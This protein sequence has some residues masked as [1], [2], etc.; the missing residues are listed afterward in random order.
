MFKKIL[1]GLTLSVSVLF[2]DGFTLVSDDLS[3]QLTND[4]VFNGFGCSGKNISPAL[5][6]KNAPKGTKSFAITMYDKDAPTG[7]GWWHWV[8]FDIPTNVTSLPKNSGDV[9][10]NLMPKGAIQSVTD[11]G[12]SG[13]GGACP[14]VGHG[15]HQYVITIYALDVDTLGLDANAKAALVGFMLNAHTLSK[16]SVIAYYGR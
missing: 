2:A 10:E 1:F 9:L 7:S 14:P 4:Q 11:F 13:Y 16:A 5:S 6:W 3:G 8:V 12:K 15:A